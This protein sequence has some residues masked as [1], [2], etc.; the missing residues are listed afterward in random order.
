MTTLLGADAATPTVLVLG[1]GTV[2]GPVLTHLRR[3]DLR[4]LQRWQLPWTQPPAR[5]RMLRAV[6][7]TLDEHAGRG[8]VRIVWAAGAAGFGADEAAAAQE[9]A[10]FNEVVDLARRLAER[11][12][13]GDHRFHL[14]SSAGAL[15]EGMT[16]R[17]PTATPA[18]RRA[19]GRL[20]LEQE[21]LA[22]A[23][24][25]AVVVHRPSSVYGAGTGG[26]RPG[27][28]GTLVARALAQDT[29][30]IYGAPTT[31]R[32]YVHADDVG[33][34]VARA[35]LEPRAPTTPQLLVA[36]RPTAI[37][38]VVRLVAQHLR[39]PVHLQYVESWNARDIV[40]T[41]GARAPGFRPASVAV[42]LHHVHRELVAAP[43]RPA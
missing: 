1:S 16:V 29:V 3:R 40:F 22:G 20:K 4:V 31:L 27:L 17:S 14:V 26:R 18:P 35:V 5:R 42:A 25:P 34:H 10:A 8:P 12:R 38:E 6:G 28:V 13:A 41:P 30:Q 11:H 21:A 9:L 24:L 7:A 36:G 32:D 33:R 39:R 37:H 43:R 15:F 19:Y 23:R 2:G